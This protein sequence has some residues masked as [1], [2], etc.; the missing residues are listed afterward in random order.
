MLENKRLHIE[1][2]PKWF[3]MTQR[4]DVTSNNKMVCVVSWTTTCLFSLLIAIN[5]LFIT[6]STFPWKEK[7]MFFICCCY[8][9]DNFN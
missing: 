1:F 4:Y 7:K 2:H 6:T 8:V 3:V 5:S 9:G